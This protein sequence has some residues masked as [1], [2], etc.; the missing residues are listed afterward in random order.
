[1]VKYGFRGDITGDID[2]DPHCE[3]IRV[4][5]VGTVLLFG[6]LNKLELGETYV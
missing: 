5:I 2:E 6:Y 3:V 1:M 4:S